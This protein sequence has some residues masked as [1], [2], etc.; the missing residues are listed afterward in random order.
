MKF[1][2]AVRAWYATH[3][4]DATEGREPL[5][6]SSR[7]EEGFVSPLDN[8]R[9]ETTMA[10]VRHDAVGN[11]GVVVAPTDDCATRRK[12]DLTILPLLV[13]VY[14]LQILDKTVLGFSAIFGL[15]DDLHLRGD[16][17]SLVG[18]IAPIAQLVVQPISS[19]LIV[20][21]PHRVL[22][23]GLV[24]GWGV[25]QTMTPFCK[26]FAQLMT[27]RFFLG[28]F[29]GGCLPLFSVITGYWYTR[30]EQ[31]LRVAA[32]YGTNGL[33]TVFAALLSFGLGRLGEGDGPKQDG[34]KGWQWIFLSTGMLTVITVPFV[35]FRLDNDIQTARFLNEREK[36]AALGRVKGNQTGS[37]SAKKNWKWR[38][39]R[40]VF[41]DIKTWFFLGMALANNLGAQ[42]TVTFGPLILSGL[43][44]DKYTTTLLNI[45]FGVMQY[46]VILA[47][48]WAAVRLKLKAPTLGGMILV[49]LAGL[50]T[51]YTLPRGQNQAG[52]L[53]A[54]FYCLAFIFG[55]NTLI[56][57]WILAN[58]A[59]Q[60]KRAAIM[61]LYN[62]ASST[63]NIVGPLLFETDD[64]PAYLPGLRATMGVFAAMLVIVL[65]QVAVLVRFNKKQEQRRVE[66][67]KP[68]RNGDLTTGSGDD[69]SHTR[70]G[71]RAF[72]DMTDLENDEFIYFY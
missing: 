58:T 25:A 21:V 53:L 12:I 69:G 43:G 3:H 10:E 8:R 31:P 23:S 45:P 22:M 20:R 14:F 32:W 68:A 49:I 50:I 29:E 54:G 2:D 36:T 27:A 66:A 41:L 37:S 5:L 7:S 34:L 38:Q 4:S 62:A 26:T 47:T 64:A 63:G 60:T 35:Y 44:Y 72:E 52:G 57:S 28:F 55:C 56:V 51:L 61:S 59:G 15:P 65:I 24:L 1:P 17:Y 48:A 39:V 46:L 9:D 70:V 13:W 33:G 16:Q 30:G 40:E 18:A 71:E 11:V 42:V 19:W 6:T 67:G